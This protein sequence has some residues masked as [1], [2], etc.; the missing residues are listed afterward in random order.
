MCTIPE[1]L[2][3]LHSETT[4]DEKKQQLFSRISTLSTTLEI[5]LAEA[6]TLSVVQVNLAILSDLYKEKVDQLRKD[7]GTKN[8]IYILQYIQNLRKLRL[9]YYALLKLLHAPFEYE[10]IKD[11]IIRIEREMEEDQNE[12]EF[13]EIQNNWII[14]K[15]NSNE[16]LL[17]ETFNLIITQKLK[18]RILPCI[19]DMENQISLEILYLQLIQV[20][21]IEESCSEVDNEI[22]P[23]VEDIKGIERELDMQDDTATQVSECNSGDVNQILHKL[24]FL[25]GHM[26]DC[27]EDHKL[28]LSLM[29]LYLQLLYKVNPLQGNT[30]NKLMEEMEILELELNPENEG[31]VMQKFNGKEM[32]DI[33]SICCE[34]ISKLEEVINQLY[35]ELQE[36]IKKK[37][38]RLIGTCKE[39]ITNAINLREKYQEMK[40]LCNASI[41]LLHQSTSEPK[42]EEIN[43]PKS[44]CTVNEP[45]KSIKEL[46]RNEPIQKQTSL[47][48]SEPSNVSTSESSNGS[49][50]KSKGQA[51]KQTKEGID[52]SGANLSKVQHLPKKAAGMPLERSIVT[53]EPS[54]EELRKK[55]VEKL[56]ELEESDTIL[57]KIQSS[58]VDEAR[59]LIAKTLSTLETRLLDAITQLNAGYQ[60]GLDM[61]S[62]LTTVENIERGYIGKAPPKKLKSLLS[63]VTEFMQFK[64]LYNQLAKTYVS[65]TKARP[66]LSHYDS[67]K[68]QALMKKYNLQ[69]KQI[70][71]EVPDYLQS[72]CFSNKP[73][74]RKELEFILKF[75]SDNKEL[76]ANQIHIPEY[77]KLNEDNKERILKYIWEVVS[78]WKDD[79]H[80][81]DYWLESEAKEQ[82]IKLNIQPIENVDRTD[83]INRA[84][85]TL[86]I[87]N[88]CKS[89][90]NY[91]IIFGPRQIEDSLYQSIVSKIKGIL[92][93]EPEV[94]IKYLLNLLNNLQYNYSVSLKKNFAITSINQL[95][96]PA[97]FKEF[98]RKILEETGPNCAIYEED[99]PSAIEDA[100]SMV[101]YH[102]YLRKKKQ[103]RKNLLYMIEQ[104][105]YKT[106]SAANIFMIIEHINKY[107]DISEFDDPLLSSSLIAD[108]NTLRK[109]L[110]DKIKYSELVK[111]KK[112]L[113]VVQSTLKPFSIRT[114]V[115]QH[116]QTCILKRSNKNIKSICEVN[117]KWMTHFLYCF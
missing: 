53:K 90:N 31:Y 6:T 91:E 112:L 37:R 3:L 86:L 5:A 110:D 113:N 39:E 26:L 54:D 107:G 58:P 104:I 12:T 43:Q 55:I 18:K 49:T 70:E 38:V 96:L 62:T 65:T 79:E 23:L 28:V 64:E 76:L 45:R 98:Q 78:H 85:L 93:E 81:E 83:N 36:F 56:V 21:I 13:P 80:I 57:D 51:N 73:E 9:F 40:L 15:L 87:L 42:H 41:N 8:A 14:E 92:P 35:D 20:V 16:E 109:G 47:P 84:R 94:K 25:K 108:A 17:D 115:T 32:T 69:I 75:Y 101:N 60:L 33:D 19:E 63:D 82:L 102:K 116:L 67:E 1:L 27:H 2:S 4:V 46:T 111:A 68:F 11:Q 97:Q 72:D 7:C 66:V 52:T 105:N 61:N 48:T 22:G 30:M 88:E 24:T 95:Y 50:S 103:I 77:S 100:I 117:P 29:D 99:P 34:R 59:E 44:E 10:E 74:D 106:E 71:S 114:L 89:R